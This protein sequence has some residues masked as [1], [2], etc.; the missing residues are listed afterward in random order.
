MDSMSSSEFRKHYARLLSPVE[1][2]VSEHV[3]GTWIPG[4]RVWD[5][6]EAERLQTRYQRDL[7]SGSCHMPG[8]V[9]QRARSFTPVPKPSK[10]R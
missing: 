10:R 7:A 8:A 5:E 2:T 6:G 1:V 3:I 4:Y 9:E